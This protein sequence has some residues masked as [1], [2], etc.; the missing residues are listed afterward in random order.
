M[1]HFDSLWDLPGISNWIHYLDQNTAEV[2]HSVLQ[3]SWQGDH[4]LN[5]CGRTSL[6]VLPRHLTACVSESKMNYVC[7]LVTQPKE[8]QIMY[9][10][11]ELGV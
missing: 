5:T 4:C 9:L 11:G 7:I 1:E 3:D 8:D 10:G 2:R 6:W